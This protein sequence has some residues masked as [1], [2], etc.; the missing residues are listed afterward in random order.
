VSYIS[1]SDMS[2]PAIM[3]G[4]AFDRFSPTSI[5]E[6]HDARMRPSVLVYALMMLNVAICATRSEPYLPVTYRWASV[7]PPGR[8][9]NIEVGHAI[10]VQGSRTV[11][12]AVPC[13][14]GSEIRYSLHRGRRRVSLRR[15]HDQDQRG[16]RFHGP[17]SRSP[18]RRGNSQE[19]PYW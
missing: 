19:I 1:P 12:K 11:R 8:K 15:T 6:A 9:V 17:I 3:G 2:R 7:A 13:S 18:P 4:T 5:G 10:H 14:I 16:R